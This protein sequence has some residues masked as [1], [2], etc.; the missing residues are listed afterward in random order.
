[1]SHGYRWTLEQILEEERR[2]RALAEEQAR[3][4]RSVLTT[5]AIQF[6]P[7]VVDAQ[8]RENPQ[9]PNN[10]APQAWQDLFS[11][12]TQTPLRQRTNGWYPQHQQDDGQL[13]ERMQQLEEENRN[14]Q[15][16][17]AAL[18][19]AK[20]NLERQMQSMTA[21]A[22]NQLT[23]E[24]AS[25]IDDVPSA[26]CNMPPAALSLPAAPPSRFASLFR[27]WERDGLVLALL[28]TT[29]WNLRHAIDEALAERVGIAVGSG[30]TKR[31]FNRLEKSG[32]VT[33]PVYD[34]GNLQAAILLLTD[35]GSSV[36]K[37][38][39]H[40]PVPSEWMILMREH[41]GEQQAKHA[42]LCCTFA[43]QARKRGWTVHLCPTVEG[44]AEPDALIV[45]D[46]R[47]I[48]VE[49]E[50]E[51]GEPE[52]RMRKWRNLADLQGFVALCANNDVVRE[53]LV[54]EARAAAPYGVATDVST[55]IQRARI[56]EEGF[57]VDKWGRGSEAPAGGR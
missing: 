5:L 54:T 18:T 27:T 14:L 38:I 15:Q 21:P 8:R 23:V 13:E 53:R 45:N 51:S 26:T 33:Q 47:S 2:L 41:G 48:Y 30:S 22:T 24:E 7:H 16:K 6:A 44:P 49:V 42:A 28:A 34:L 1:M 25:S 56:G 43:Y 29:G 19:A 9:F 3:A 11:Q 52:R 40:D 31:V 12:I 17:V 37:A 4:Y 36:A 20:E 10:L 32:L 57:W 55:L 35:K 46:E 39:G 50:A